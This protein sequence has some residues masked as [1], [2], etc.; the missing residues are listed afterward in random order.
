MLTSE[1]IELVN[2]FT[3]G[4]SRF[5]LL[6]IAALISRRLTLAEAFGSLSV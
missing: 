5:H 3:S 4:L 1:S 2:P 6:E